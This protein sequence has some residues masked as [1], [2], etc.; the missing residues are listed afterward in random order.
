MRRRMK[1]LHG[2]RRGAH[3]RRDPE[4]EKLW[5]AMAFDAWMLLAAVV[6]VLAGFFQLIDRSMLVIP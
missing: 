3:F 4:R 1:R 6:P 2:R 5:G